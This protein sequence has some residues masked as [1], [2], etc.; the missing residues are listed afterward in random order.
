M[1]RRGGTASGAFPYESRGGCWAL[2][3]A[4]CGS[5]WA[6]A[7]AV[8]PRAKNAAA[9][10][11]RWRF[12]AILLEQMGGHR[13]LGCKLLNKLGGIGRRRGQSAPTWWFSAS[14]L[15]NLLLQHQRQDFAHVLHVANLHAIEL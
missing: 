12:M 7:P 1:L 4:I 9:V 11:I 6:Q 15:T 13:G 14:R 2:S 5:D 10:R 8:T 3:G